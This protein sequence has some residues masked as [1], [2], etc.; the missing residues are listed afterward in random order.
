MM[1]RTPKNQIIDDRPRFLAPC[2]ERRPD[3]SSIEIGKRQ[4]LFPSL[5]L[6]FVYPSKGS[7]A[8]SVSSQLGGSVGRTGVLFT[9][10]G[11][12]QIPVEPS[13]RHRDKSA[14]VSMLTLLR[15]VIGLVV[16]SGC[17][18]P[19][20]NPGERTSDRATMSGD[21]AEAFAIVKPAAERGE[22]WAQLRLGIFYENGWGVAQN[23][24]MA[25]EWYEKAMSQKA[26]GGWAEGQLVGATGRFGYFNQNSDAR[27]A[28][29]NLAQLLSKGYPSHGVDKDV[30]R[31]HALV[32]YVIDDSQGKDIF[33]C[34]EFA[35]SRWFSQQQFSDLLQKLTP[36]MTAEQ[37]RQAEELARIYRRKFSIPQ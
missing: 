20:P 31:A 6:Q 11:A 26:Q 9:G 25:I 28:A 35:G 27:I 8:G 29:F 30:V 23:P 37:L 36:D 16:L 14:E 33:F 17:A 12:C 4:A 1:E 15:F 22:P 7:E 13:D 32:T 18:G 21:F 3:C 10:V 19:N 2:G 24:R 34:C 5:L